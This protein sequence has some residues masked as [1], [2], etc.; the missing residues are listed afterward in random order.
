[1]K[2]SSFLP[3]F[4]TNFCGVVNDNFLKTLASF[5]VLG[6]LG[7]DERL[8][9]LFLGLTAAALVLP[10]ILCSPLADRLTV[11]FPKRRIVCFAKW[12]ELPIVAVAML[13]FS[14]QSVAL[15]VGAIL[16]MGLQSALYSPSK[17]ALVRDIGGEDRIS[18]GMGGMEG[19]A[20]LAVLTGTIVAAF[21]ADNVAPWVWYASLAGFAVLGLG[22][23][24]TIRAEEEMSR[25]VHAINPVRY[26]VRARRMARRYPGLNAVIVTLSVFWF[27][28]AML[29]QGLLVYGKDVLGLDGLRTGGILA[30]AAVG[31]VAGQ[32][33]AGLVDRRR[34][35]LGSTLLTGW[36]AAVL[37]GVLF[38]A[39]L[40]PTAFAVVTGLL[41]FDLGFFK[42]PLDAEIQKVVKGPK[43]NTMLAYFNQVS[44]LFMFFASICYIGISCLCGHRAFLVFLSA[45]MLVVP[46]IFVFSYRSVLLFTGRW[47]FHRRYKVKVEGLD[48]ILHS[49]SLPA[50]ASPLLVLPNH[51]AMVD[52]MLVGAEF[53]RAPVKPLAD[54]SFF[55]TGIVAP[56]V[57]RTLGA[58]EVPDLRKRRSAKGA[59]IARGLGDIVKETL[60]DG[61]NV[62]F[63]PAGHIYTDPM[64][65]PAKD[66]SVRHAKS[67]EPLEDI[68]TRQL[69]YNICR[70]LPEGLRVIGVRTT[71]LWG[72]I[73]SRKGRTTSPAFVPT[74]IK[75]VLLWFFV[76]PFV[77]RRNVTMHVE[78][79]TD[80]VKAWSATLT[81]LDFNARLNAWYNGET[82]NE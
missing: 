66:G 43:L 34:F 8:H 11:V 19:I 50:P 14:L 9:S 58:V 77:P 6:W 4:I 80:R 16:L 68:G 25:N 42:L 51:P 76:A 56:A 74:F 72:S 26:L 82:G 64:L 55:R 78:D 69:A 5:V 46:F 28:A 62:I 23:S 22:F 47:I 10:Y 20:F 67:G 53:W 30:L 13:G 59:T 75:S 1:M 65:E 7:D 29:Q 70:D 79:I 44:F 24:Y 63:Y 31:I 49:S 21:A 15:V 45:V 71:G 32:I 57:L 38:F 36:I 17:Y 60:M 61:G 52:P 27:V 81:R 54:E 12:A 39:P 40:G 73:W 18:T 37:L 41:A 33:L 48:A 3:L 2:R 35:L